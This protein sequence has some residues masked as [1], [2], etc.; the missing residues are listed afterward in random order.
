MRHLYSFLEKSRQKIS[1]EFIFLNKK[2]ENRFSLRIHICQLFSFVEPFILIRNEVYYHS[3]PP[4]FCFLSFHQFICPR[5]FASK[6][7]IVFSYFQF[8]AKLQW[9]RSNVRSHPI[10]YPDR[11]LP[12]I[13]VAMLVHR[14]QNVDEIVPSNFTEFQNWFRKFVLLNFRAAV[15]SSV[16]R[17][18][19]RSSRGGSRSPNVRK[20]ARQR[21]VSPPAHQ[22]SSSKRRHHKDGVDSGRNICQICSKD[23]ESTKRLYGLL[24]N[25]DHVL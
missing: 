7:P 19:S 11:P 2:L 12:T 9:V 18:R 25:C 20:P 21:S 10:H 8:Q 22:S 23:V 16:S 24:D 14:H 5:L 15:R 3:H 17:S 13:V 6:T 4:T 1:I